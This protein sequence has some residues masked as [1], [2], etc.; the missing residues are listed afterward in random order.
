[1]PFLDLFKTLLSKL[2]LYKQSTK[3]QEIKFIICSPRT[4]ES[5][6][7]GIQKPSMIPPWVTADR[8]PDEFSRRDDSTWIWVEIV[9]Q[10]QVLKWIWCTRNIWKSWGTLWFS[11]DTGGRS[12]HMWGDKGGS[13]SMCLTTWQQG[14]PYLLPSYQTWKWCAIKAQGENY[15]QLNV[16]KKHLQ[17]RK[18]W[19]CDMKGSSD[20]IS[21]LYIIE[22]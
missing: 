19:S 2:S 6:Q 13:L 5:S 21:P 9:T 1:M 10:T 20:N 3:V 8:S 14:T 7:L 11:A 12:G 17:H 22:K 4:P 18:A 15:S 16:S